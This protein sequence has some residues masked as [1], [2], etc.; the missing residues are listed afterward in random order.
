MIRVALGSLSPLLASM[1]AP[2]VQ[3]ADDMVFVEMAPVV[4][5]GPP[6]DEGPDV[7]LVGSQFDDAEILGELRRR[8]ALCVLRIEGNGHD[9]TIHELQPRSRVHQDSTP[10]LLLDLIRNAARDGAST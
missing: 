3:E 2:L 1:V 9:L 6:S 7:L 5:P 8:P 4:S 10:E